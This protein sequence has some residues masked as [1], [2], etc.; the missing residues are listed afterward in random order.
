MSTIEEMSEELRSFGVQYGELTGED[1]LIVRG[2]QFG[3]GVT[4]E[5]L[6]LRRR[7]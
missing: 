2:K 3:F 4:D 1:D 6:S 5:I 7:R